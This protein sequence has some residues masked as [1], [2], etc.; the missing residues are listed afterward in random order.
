MNKIVG[1]FI[2][3]T[4]VLSDI[5]QSYDSNKEFDPLNSNEIPKKILDIINQIINSKGDFGYVVSSPLAFIEIANQFDIISTD[6]YTYARF[7]SFIRQ[8]P[9]WFLIEPISLECVKALH[10]IDQ[11]VTV[12][13]KLVPIEINDAIHVATAIARD[14]YNALIGSKD[15]R[16][17]EITLMKNKVI[18]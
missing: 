3:D 14:K 16:I 17:R 4:H 5:I 6:K 12:A 13:N 8:P 7:R 18:F 2:V 1:D 11:F 15:I 10:D 9:G